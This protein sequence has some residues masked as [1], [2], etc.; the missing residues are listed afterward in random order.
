[1]FLEL[2][3]LLPMF[4]LIGLGIV[5]GRI[6]DLKAA[7]FRKIVAGNSTLHLGVCLRIQADLFF[8]RG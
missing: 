2:V 6:A 1:M 3:W 8:F 7:R 5:P 4:L